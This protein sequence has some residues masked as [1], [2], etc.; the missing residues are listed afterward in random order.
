MSTRLWIATLDVA[1]PLTLSVGVETVFEAWKA[2]IAADPNL[3]QIYLCC[4][5]VHH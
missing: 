1:I 4:C 5:I 3:E 2:E